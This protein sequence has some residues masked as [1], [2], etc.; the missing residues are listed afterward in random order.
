MLP[1]HTPD[2]LQRQLHAIS[3][4]YSRAGLVVNSK[5][6]EVLYLPSDSSLPQ[7]FYISRDQLGLTEQFAYL[8]SVITSTCDL[9][10]E[11][12]HRVNLASASFRRL[13]KRVFTKRDLS[14]RTKMAVC[15]AICVSTLLYACEGWTPYCR[16]IRALGAF[17]IRCL[18]TIRHVHWWDKKTHVEIRRRAGTTCL[19]TILLRKQLRWLGHV[20]RMPGNRL[21]C[22]LL[23]SK[24]S[25]GRR[26]VGGQK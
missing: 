17:H 9:T 4:A 3:S 1:S 22:R 21:P 18:Q 26:S 19:E 5:K 12:Q 10:A 13:P 11:I 24:L 16:H 14:T 2:G 8:G 20:I 15:N 6:T 25:C 7:T 23:D